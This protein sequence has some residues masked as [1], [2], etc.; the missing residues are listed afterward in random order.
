[1]DFWEVIK[2]TPRDQGVQKTRDNLECD[3]SYMLQHDECNFYV[4]NDA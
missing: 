1:M 4:F 3:F 2:V